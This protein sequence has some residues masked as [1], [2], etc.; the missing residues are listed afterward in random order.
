MHINEHRPCKAVV[1]L[2]RFVTI[3]NLNRSQL[4]ACSHLTL[5]GLLTMPW[6]IGKKGLC[7]LV[8]SLPGRLSHTGKQ[9]TIRGLWLSQ[10]DRSYSRCPASSRQC[11]VKLL[12]SCERTRRGKNSKSSVDHTSNLNWRPYLGEGKGSSCYD[13]GPGLLIIGLTETLPG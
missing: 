13:T 7:I 12:L 4:R 9:I 1:L 10:N 3:D 8:F 5:R 11:F 6:S 2:W